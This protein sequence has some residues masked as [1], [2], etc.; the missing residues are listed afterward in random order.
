MIS[1]FFWATMLF[2]HILRNG[3]AGYSRGDWGT[4]GEVGE[5]VPT[6]PT[7]ALTYR[8]VYQLSIILEAFEKREHKKYS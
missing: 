7:F 8:L 3:C 4:L 2:P 6:L 5:P 1:S